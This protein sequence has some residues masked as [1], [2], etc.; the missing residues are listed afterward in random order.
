MAQQTINN[1]AVQPLGGPNG[2]T[3]T[4]Q[5]DTWDNAV[6]KMNAMFTEMYGGSRVIAAGTSTALFGA[7]G[8]I[9]RTVGA[10]SSSATNTTQT[11][12]SYVLPANALAVN[13]EGIMVTAFGTTAANAAGKTLQ[14][15]VGG[16]TVNTG[17]QVFS[18]SGWMLEGTY[19]RSG[20]AAQVGNLNAVFGSTINKTVSATDTS[21]DTGTINIA[22]T[23]LDASAGS[24]NI[25]ALALIVEYFG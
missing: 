25:T 12:M 18:G 4:E 19:F 16:I 23:C 21:S 7:S 6:V 11:L 10:V 2:G 20:S 1:N 8:N 5:G 3:S 13:G 17:N 15:A 14:L 22:V 24:A 9:N